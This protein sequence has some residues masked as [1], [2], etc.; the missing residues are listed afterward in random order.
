[1]LAGWRGEGGMS[2]MQGTLSHF[3]V[4]RKRGLHDGGRHSPE[5]GRMF[6]QVTN[7]A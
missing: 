3:P 2:G 6:L 1:M 7:T 5:L 4:E